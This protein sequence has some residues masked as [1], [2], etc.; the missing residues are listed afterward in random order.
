MSEALDSLWREVR[1]CTLCA[2]DLPLGPR[3]VLRPS[4]T[5][6]LLIVGQAPG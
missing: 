3:P 5:A 1:G 4:A 6:R 2:A